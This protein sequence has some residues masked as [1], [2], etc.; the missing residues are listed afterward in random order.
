MRGERGEEMGLIHDICMI[1]ISPPRYFEE[2]GFFPLMRLCIFMIEKESKGEVDGMN[3]FYFKR[4]FFFINKFEAFP[5]CHAYPRTEDGSCF[6]TSII[7]SK[8]LGHEG[9]EAGSG[10][11]AVHVNE[12]LHTMW[13][14]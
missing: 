4:R 14:R 3:P 13:P 10:R 7:S 8:K 11:I 12:L 2:V 6:G 1:M 5:L 9:T